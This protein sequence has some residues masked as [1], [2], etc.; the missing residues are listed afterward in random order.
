[1]WSAI[2]NR[3]PYI[4]PACAKLFQFSAHDEKPA[5]FRQRRLH[6]S[7]K[8][9]QDAIFN[10]SSETTKYTTFTHMYKHREDEITQNKLK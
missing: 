2:K 4:V 9:Q 10:Y 7:F 8:T 6:N 1:M 3:Q 5:Q